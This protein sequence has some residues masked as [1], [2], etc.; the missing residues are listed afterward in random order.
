MTKSDILRDYKVSDGIILTPGKFEGEPVYVPVFWARGLEGFADLD[1][2]G[3]FAF[4]ITNEDTAE[5]P[6]L[7]GINT[8][9]LEES[10]SGFVACSDW[11][12]LAILERHLESLA[13]EDADED[14]F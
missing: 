10:E 4:E 9:A 6:E 2:D 7:E 3:V 14:E 8:L 1:E 11:Q 13:D 12:S 5:F